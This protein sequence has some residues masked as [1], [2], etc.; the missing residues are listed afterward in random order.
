M[1]Y[2]TEDSGWIEGD[3]AARV[4]GPVMVLRVLRLAR[5][6]RALRLLA[7]FKELWMLVRGLLSSAGTMIYTF[8]LI[9]IIL[10]VFACMGMELIT[11]D[12]DSRE[13]P[14]FDGY[15][16]LYFPGIWVTMLTLIQFVM[17]DSIAEIYTPM[18]SKNP[19]LGI[20]FVLILMIVPISLMN[21]VTAVI[22]E[23]SL[24]QAKEDQE[25][26]KTYKNKLIVKM[27]PRIEKMFERL[28][29]DGSGDISLK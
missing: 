24:E 11:T 16:E 27:M 2:V 7:Q 14:E 19:M 26:A 8:I 29:V 13:D 23:G 1:M 21:L 4:L 18:V 28:D 17:V 12:M 6:A 9:M 3:T 15:V 10:Y 25:V 20:Y 5:L 22:V